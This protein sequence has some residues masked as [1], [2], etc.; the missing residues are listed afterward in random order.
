[1]F[2][3]KR[4]CLGD[5]LAKVCLFLCF[6]EVL[7]RFRIENGCEGMVPSGKP[8]PGILMTTEQY[9]AKFVPRY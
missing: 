4:R 1:M 9:V 5:A 6:V 2:V 3:G 8:V 7:R